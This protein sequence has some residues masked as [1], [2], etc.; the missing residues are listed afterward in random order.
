MMQPLASASRPGGLDDAAMQG[1]FALAVRLYTHELYAQ[2][3]RVM[4]YLLRHEPARPQYQRALGKAL[5]AA[6][7]HEEALQA[8]ARA[9]KLG[10]PDADVHFYI[11]Q[12]LVYTHRRGPAQMA[13]QRC[14]ALARQQ[15][16]QQAGLI[17]RAE[18]LLK[19]LEQLDRKTADPAAPASRVD[20]PMKEQP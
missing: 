5:H 10:M 6:G 9:V 14:L 8:Y 4:Q 2:S 18:L 13:L 17:T 3:A 20:M 1:L 16:R 7:Q 12:C 15:A 19:R 11:A